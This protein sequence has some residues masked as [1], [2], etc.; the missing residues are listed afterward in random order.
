MAVPDG[1][2]ALAKIGITYKYGYVAGTAY[3]QLDAVYYEGST[4]LALIDSPTGVPRD[5]GTNWKYLAKGFPS[6]IDEV[7]LRFEAAESR[8]NIASGEKMKTVLGKIKKWFADQTAAAFAQ[9]ISSYADLMSNTVAGYLADGL[10][11]K[12]GFNELSTKAV[13]L[14]NGTVSDWALSN[15]LTIDVTSEIQA[16]IDKGFPQVI[17]FQFGSGSQSIGVAAGQASA[18][19]TVN[20]IDTWVGACQIIEGKTAFFVKQDNKI[21]IWCDEN[22]SLAL[23]NVLLMKNV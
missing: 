15:Y 4:Y 8:E 9:V 19:T 2:K 20:G 13:N 17:R 1:Y 23:R 16:Q 10:A 18:I 11:I 12:D 22:P 14:Y 21:Y 3:S 7:E 5:D 6:Y